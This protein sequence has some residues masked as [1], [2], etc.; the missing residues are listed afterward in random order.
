MDLKLIGVGYTAKVYEYYND[1]V[2][3]LFKEGY[4]KSYIEHEFSNS[5]KV[6]ELVFNKIKSY[7]LISY[8]KQYGIVYDKAI[9]INLLD[10]VLSNM[11][12]KSAGII[13]ADEHNNILKNSSNSFYQIVFKLKK[14]VEESYLLEESQKKLLSSIIASLPVGNTVCHGDLHP[15]NI[16]IGD[17]NYVIDYMNICI[18]HPHYDIARTVY[19]TEMTPMPDLGEKTEE[20]SQ[21][22]NYLIDNYLERI[23]NLRGESIT[24]ESL[25]NWFL[26]IAGSRL[27]EIDTESERNNL[28][29]YLVNMGIV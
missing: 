22:R 1:R 14:D 15:G 10:W 11:D 17:K 24:R 9:G 25:K 18:G 19:L 6:N 26:A 16:I 8:E 2:L 21:L 13:M 5:L 4:P 3:K 20:L 29:R 23:S 28:K 27:T 7:E 12:G